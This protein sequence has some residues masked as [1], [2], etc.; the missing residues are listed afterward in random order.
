MCSGPSMLSIMLNRP[1]FRVVMAFLV[2]MVPLVVMANEKRL[3]LGKAVWMAAFMAG[4]F[5]RG[6][7]P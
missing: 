2:D 5:S 7:P 6:S 3:P 4:R 1:F